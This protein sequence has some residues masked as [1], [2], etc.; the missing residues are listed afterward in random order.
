MIIIEDD[1]EEM[2]SELRA[3]SCPENCQHDVPLTVAPMLAMPV[4]LYNQKL[5]RDSL[6][7]IYIFSTVLYTHQ[8]SMPHNL[9]ID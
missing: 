5:F 3:V 4:V 2:P 8:K 9:Q 6:R 7:Y 1:P